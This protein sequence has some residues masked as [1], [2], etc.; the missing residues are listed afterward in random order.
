MKKGPISTAVMQKSRRHGIGASWAVRREGTWV[1]T[2]AHGTPKPGICSR[3]VQKERCA[4]GRQPT[5]IAGRSGW[6]MAR[7]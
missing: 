7:H 2:R 5:D 6:Q 1:R 4:S 3:R